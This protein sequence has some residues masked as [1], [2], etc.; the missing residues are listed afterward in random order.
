[1]SDTGAVF[2]STDN[3]NT[4]SWTFVGPAG[5]ARRLKG[6]V[7]GSGSNQNFFVADGEDGVTLIGPVDPLSGT[8]SWYQVGGP[9]VFLRGAA[10]DKSR[11]VAVGSDD[12][13]LQSKTLPW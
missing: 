10:F 1:V 6:V 8:I 9:T 11:F 13:I 7:F 2:V 4:W 12:T 3:G 5:A